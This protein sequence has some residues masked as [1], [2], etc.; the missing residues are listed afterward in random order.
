[1]LVTFLALSCLALL[2]TPFALNF[3]LALYTALRWCL[4]AA[5][6]LHLIFAHLDLQRFVKV[7]LAGL[8]VQVLVGMGQVLLQRPLGLPGE[9]ALSLSQ[10][11]A[12]VV[13]IAGQNWL[14][15]YGLTF[16]PNVFGG[17][18][19]I[20]LLLAMPFL[21]RISAWLFVWWLLW[22]GLIITFSRAAL[23]AAVI[24][25][26]IATLW[27]YWQRPSCRR[28]L[29]LAIAGLLLI[30]AAGAALFSEQFATRL[31]MGH[32]TE[33][34]SLGEREAQLQVALGIISTRPI[35]GVGAGNFPLAVPS[36]GFDLRAL[37]VHNIPL[38]L[39]SEVGVLGGA[40]WVWATIMALVRLRR[41]MQRRNEWVVVG[42]CSW[43]A[44]GFIAL[45][46]FY[47]W[48][49]NAGRLLSAMVVGLT[50][51]AMLDDEPLNNESCH[52]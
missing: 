31:G 7:F 22:A 23:L 44:L 24:T 46:D 36:S 45:F 17:Y 48:G 4:A 28:S 32:V 12:A 27:L 26:P 14:R 29:G 50:G 42:L 52:G 49:L 2:T 20:A 39:A 30:G 1:L 3:S 19:V 15:A 21:L 34:L 25:V 47:P 5:I 10:P 6:S 35:S 8:L 11:G 33:W 16:H 51:H 18:L 43:L 40:V 9:M 41:W 38:L 37:P 13:A